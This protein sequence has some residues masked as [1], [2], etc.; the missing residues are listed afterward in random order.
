MMGN[1]RLS[2]CF[3]INCLIRSPF[4]D[5]VSLDISYFCYFALSKAFLFFS[6]FFQSF[7]VMLN[8]GIHSRHSFPFLFVVETVLTF[9]S[10]KSLFVI[11]SERYLTVKLR[12]F[13]IQFFPRFC[14]V[15]SV[16]FWGILL[17]GHT[18]F[19]L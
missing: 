2:L 16:T 12:N 13:L 17:R 10:S 14:G 9:I 15:L 3:L 11:G 8:T 5:C 4:I 7:S 1:G 18:V 19:F 6:F